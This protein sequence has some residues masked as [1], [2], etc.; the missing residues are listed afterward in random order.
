MMNS[1]E[2]HFRTVYSNGRTHGNFAFA[3]V[4][5]LHGNGGAFLSMY[6]YIQIF[7][8]KMTSPT[9][10]VSPSGQDTQPSL[11]FCHKRGE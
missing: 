10:L 7:V 5:E 6:I 3:M 11:T 4:F 1:V 9:P 8:S 2:N